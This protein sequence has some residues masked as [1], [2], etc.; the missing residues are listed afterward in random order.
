[1]IDKLIFNSNMVSLT[2]ICILLPLA[3]LHL[4]QEDDYM[5]EERDYDQEERPKM[6]FS[7]W[8]AMKKLF[9]SFVLDRNIN[10]IKDV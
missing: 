5:K 7:Y 8:L 10:Q 9:T 2:I 4:S 1:M 6:R 3:S